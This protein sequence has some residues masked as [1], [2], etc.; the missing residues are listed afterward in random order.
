MAESK[1]Y[2]NII[3]L[4]EGTLLTEEN[5]VRITR[6]FANREI[7]TV[8]R[9]LAGIVKG[10]AIMRINIRNAVPAKGVEYDPGPDGA[11]AKPKEF[12]FIRGAQQLTGKMIVM[13]DETSHQANN[14]SELNF[15]MVGPLTQWEPL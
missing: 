4:R 11:A 14:E 8:A 1:Y 5:Q 3:V 2:S 13:Q 10:A 7:F 12:T 6:D 9:G 15:D